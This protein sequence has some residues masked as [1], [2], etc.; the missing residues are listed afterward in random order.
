MT[1]RAFFL[2]SSACL[3]LAACS[4]RA[5]QDASDDH[6]ASRAPETMADS[7]PGAPDPGEDERALSG[8]GP[9]SDE[10]AGL[11]PL[12]GYGHE[13]NWHVRV[14]R[15]T[16]TLYRQIE[17]LVSFPTRQPEA[18]PASLQ[19]NDPEG[20]AHVVFERAIC[21][22]IAT[23]MPHP[24]T[25]RAHSGAQA[26]HGCGGD[27]E[28]LFADA[29]WTLALLGDETLISERQLSIRFEDGRVSG[30]GGCNRFT[31]GYRLT[32]EALTLNRLAT[33]QMACAMDVMA[34]ENSLLARLAQVSMLDL[35]DDGALVLRTGRG[36]TI[37][38]YRTE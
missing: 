11:L 36:E 2:I 3:F 8:G 21:R 22:D 28:I 32:G 23:G 17:P 16:T 7:T 31:G 30:S 4:G 1:A 20:P 26:F 14:E 37:T 18:A 27:P 24:F 35:T 34:Q 13:P 15:E 12:R 33:S 25:V 9:L 10:I 5:D 6:G 38:A 19:F 29:N